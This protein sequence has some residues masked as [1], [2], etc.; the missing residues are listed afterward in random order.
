MAEAVF[1]KDLITCSICLDPLKDPV[2]TACGHS[3]CMGCIKES[4]DQDDGKGVYSCPQCRQTFTPRPVLGKNT[5]LNELVEKL[6]MTGL[7]AAPPAYCCAGPLDVGCD[8]C[9]GRKLK[10]VKSC[11]L[12]LASYCAT[13]LKLHNDLNQGKKHKLIDATRLQEKICTRHDKLLEVYCRTDQQ[14]ICLLCVIDDHKGHDIVAAAE[15][16]TEKQKQLGG[17]N[18]KSQ[19]RIQEREKE[20]QKLRQAV[21]SLKR[22]AQAELFDSERTLTEL[23][24]SVEKRRSEVKELISAQEKAQVSRAKRHLKQLEQ[25]VAE[26]RR[27]DAELKHLSHTE[28]HIHFLQHFQSLCVPLGSE[29]TPSIIVTFKHVNK[30]VTELKERLQDICK[31]E[32]DRIYGKVTKVPNIC[33]SE[34]KT[35]EEFLEYCCP[36]TLDPNTA[37]QLLCLSEG[38]RKVTRSHKIQTYPNH[39]HRFS[40]WKQVLCKEGVWSVSEP[41]YWEVEWTGVEVDVAVS[42]KGI[43][44]RG[45]GHECWF[46]ANDQSWRLYCSASR[47][48]FYHNGR[49]T[50]IPAIRS[51]S[52]VGVYLDHRGGTLSFYSVTVSDTMTLLHGVKTTFTRP[53]YPGFGVGSSVRILTPFMSSN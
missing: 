1:D 41:C 16:R 13:H 8:I 11:L 14:C 20:M 46:G 15:E 24:H 6:M 9:A 18:L 51:D 23:I 32:M 34:P 17:N 40:H 28:D 22:S 4:W 42:Y 37:N 19:Q 47:C 33:P 48:C 27:R 10:A 50:S 49:E 36:L 45:I 3:Y 21:D 53:L 7:Q 2:T 30:F 44:R 29:G 26:L 38:N 43:S 5:L 31:E 39:E 25:E 12:C 52:R 35:R